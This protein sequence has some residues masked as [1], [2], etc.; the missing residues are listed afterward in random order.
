MSPNGG[1]DYL[2][3]ASRD[4]EVVDR[5]ILCVLGWVSQEI[6]IKSESGA[7]QGQIDCMIGFHN[8]VVYTTSTLIFVY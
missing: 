7:E 8:S 3:P 1:S 5:F 2:L 4:V 6:I